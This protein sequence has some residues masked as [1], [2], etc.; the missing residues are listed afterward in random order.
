VTE[1]LFYQSPRALTRTVEDDV[2]LASQRHE[3]VDR[4]SGTART[5]W[6]LL[7]SPRTLESLLDALAGIFAAERGAIAADVESLLR[8]LEAR[9]MVERVADGDD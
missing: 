2:L 8:D 9:G 4:L 7:E 5:V 1:V 6:E 3:G